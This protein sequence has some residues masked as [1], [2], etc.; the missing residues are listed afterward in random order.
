MKK[1]VMYLS[2]VAVLVSCNHKNAASDWEEKSNSLEF[3]SIV[4]LTHIAQPLEADC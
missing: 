1:I 4:S 2:F 3:D